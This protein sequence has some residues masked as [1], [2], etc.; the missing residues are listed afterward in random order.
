MA[1]L[2]KEAQQIQDSYCQDFCPEHQYL[3][4]MV[5][6]AVP[7]WIFVL[8]VSSISALALTFGG[9]QINTL[10][11]LAKE[12]EKD[13]ANYR[14][15]IRESL[16]AREKYI[17]TRIIAANLKYTEDVARFISM[18]NENKLKLERIQLTIE[19]LKIEQGK[20]QV[21]QDLVLEKIG[22]TG[23]HNESAH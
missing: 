15:N 23:R 5:K 18:V 11:D 19:E 10:K 6:R 4:E 12:Q 14:L 20:F 8:S 3:K 16:S 17:D 1:H 13:N 2:S 7:R 21:K 22:L 9:W